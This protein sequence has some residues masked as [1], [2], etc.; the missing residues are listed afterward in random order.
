MTTFKAV[1]SYNGSRYYG[2]QK[3]PN[4]PTIQGHIEEVL[5]KISQS[6][7]VL[8]IG[9]GRTDRGVHALKQVVKIQIPLAIEVSSLKRALNSLL[10]SDIKCIDIEACE[11]AFQP[12]FDVAKKTYRYYF[13]FEEQSPFYIGRV[14]FLK[15][16]L[17]LDKLQQACL[18]FQGVRDFKNYY[19]TG[20][21]VKSTVREIYSCQLIKVGSNEFLPLDNLFCIE[22]IGEGFLKQM[23]RLIVSTIWAYAD[24]KVSEEEILNSFDVELKE[25]LAPTAPADGLYLF[26]VSY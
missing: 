2:W 11:E 26:D 3:Q 21:P 24:F 8:T 10:P 17:D 20:T 16:S 25:K 18:L 23:V 6:D 22:L 9:C 5:K 13:C 4:V 14:T 7:E 15:K 19:T 12:V 1:F